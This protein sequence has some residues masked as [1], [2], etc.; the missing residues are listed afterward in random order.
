MSR[1]KSEKL[2]LQDRDVNIFKYLDRVGYANLEQITEFIHDDISEKT[3]NALLRRLYLL[4]R[5]EYL[6]AHHTQLGLYYSLTNKSKLTNRL[7]GGIKYDLLLHHNFLLK[8]FYLVRDLDVLTER[9]VLAKYKLIGK[10]GKI[11]DMI[12]NEWVI[13]YE[14]TNKSVKDSQEVI[15]YW[16][17]E[18]SKKLCV[19]YESEEIKTRYQKLITSDRVRLLSSSSYEDL[20]KIVNN[21]DKK[22]NDEYNDELKHV[23]H[24]NA[25]DGI[26]DKY[27]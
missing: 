26:L 27:K 16:V 5:F 23:K 22:V 20:L 8:L 3:Q 9:E 2:L 21:E 17:I 25:L 24:V 11:P 6:K 19:I 4:R 1:A 12:V 7:I 14:R 10:N 15:N 13:E 18:Q